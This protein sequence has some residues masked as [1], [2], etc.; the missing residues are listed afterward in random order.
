MGGVYNRRLSLVFFAAIPSTDNHEYETILYEIIGSDKILAGL[1]RAPVENIEFQEIF[2]HLRAFQAITKS[3]QDESLDLSDVRYM[4]ETF[5]EK[6]PILREFM[7][8]NAQIVHSSE[9]ESAL[10]KI[11]EEAYDSF[12]VQERDSVK[13]LSKPIIKTESETA[14]ENFAHEIIKKRKVE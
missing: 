11:Q 9:F 8:Q 1:L 12:D 5:L 6:Y 10:V 14:G 4:F 7:S 2:G 3:L 13:H